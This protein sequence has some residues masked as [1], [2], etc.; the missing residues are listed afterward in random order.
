[1]LSA[2]QEISLGSRRD[3]PGVRTNF[4]TK[5]MKNTSLVL[6][7][8]CCLLLNPFPFCIRY[9]FCFFCMLAMPVIL[10]AWRLGRG[11][12]GQTVEEKCLRGS[13]TFL[14]LGQDALQRLPRCTALLSRTFHEDE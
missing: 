1:M 2:R 13:R 9:N 7:L 10:S 11:A 8:A 5:Q 6:S 12:R 4:S 14:R 3:I